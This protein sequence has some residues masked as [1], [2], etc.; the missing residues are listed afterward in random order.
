M[1]KYTGPKCRYCR[2]ERTQLYLKGDRCVSGKC[3]LR[4]DNGKR[5][6]LPGSNP[7]NKVSHKL[8][9]YGV[10]LREK[11]KLKR[12]YGM[13]EKQFHLTY[14][15]A[16]SM[17]GVTGQNMIEL[18]ERR[19]DNV[20]FRLHFA[21]SRSQARALV[22]HGHIFVNDHRV[23]IPSYQVKNGDVISVRKQSQNI[24]F[25]KANLEEYSKKQNNTVSW[26]NLDTTAMTGKFVSAPVKAEIQDL[27]KVNEQL[28]VELYSK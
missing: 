28:I 6:S 24:A 15:K 2:A 11:Q 1:A 23:D 22:C 19:L 16:S 17:P 14:L 10:Q 8:T 3:P 26:L 4:K 25:I 21:K 18:L 20:V 5:S 9:D 27:E 7:K 12:M 13:L